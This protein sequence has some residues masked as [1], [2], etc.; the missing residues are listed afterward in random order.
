M[1]LQKL[2]LTDY[3]NYAA[4][5]IEFHPGVNLLYGGNAQG[6]T[7]LLE[8]VELL[9]SGKAFRAARDA[10]AVRF[11][12]GFARLRGEIDCGS[13]SREIDITLPREG[14]KI[15]L[16]DKAPAAAQS[17]AGKLPCVLFTP[18]HL[19]LIKSGP[20]ER[21]KLINSILCQLR[22]RYSALLTQYNRIV[23]QKT[24]ILRQAEER[25]DMLEVL[26]DYN[27]RMAEIGAELIRFRA[28]FVRILSKAAPRLHAE[29]SG[30]EMLSVEYE[31]VSSV[32]DHFAESEVLKNQLYSRLCSLR[33]AEIAARACLSGP[34]RDDLLITVDGREARQYAS[35]GQCRTAAVALKLASRH[36]MEKELGV[37]PLLL[38]DDIL[39]ELDARRQ[40]YVLNRI[41]RG[42]IFIT[43]CEDEAARRLRAGRIF[44]ISAGT[45]AGRRDFGQRV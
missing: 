42:Q 11:G 31:T 9:S 37:I 41:D 35:Q 8:A 45:V 3:R 15:I 38:L 20:A 19:N 43:G 39:S 28:A 10:E 26:E 33:A 12:A 36:I 24:A 30:G 44:E 2:S 23:V 18:E 17:L 21:R 27:R 4:A 14:K 34:H 5:E 7:N 29:I 16:I 6:K 25:G 13:R 1:Y 22:P 32:E 40:D